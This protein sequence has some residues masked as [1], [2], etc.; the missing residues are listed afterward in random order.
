LNVKGLTIIMT[1]AQCIS[2]L[3][4]ASEPRESPVT[5]SERK[6]EAPLKPQKRNTYPGERGGWG[7]ART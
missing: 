6:D 7:S 1:M 3:E 4:P 2:E 5:V